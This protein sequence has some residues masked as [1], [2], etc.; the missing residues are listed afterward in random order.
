MGLDMALVRKVNEQEQEV[1]YWRKANAIHNWFVQNVQEG[2]DDC[3]TYPVTKEQ[4]QKLLSVCLEILSGNSIVSEVLPTTSG[5]FFGSTNYDS[6]Y[7]KNIEYTVESLQQIIS[8]E[9]QDNLYY[10]SSW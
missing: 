10:T 7:Y 1:M 4:L 9:W 8:E 3:G 6:W 5:F 2:V